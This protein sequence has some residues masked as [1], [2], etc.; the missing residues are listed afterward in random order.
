[1]GIKIE[2]SSYLGTAKTFLKIIGT[3][4]GRNMNCQDIS[5]SWRSFS[6]RRSYFHICHVGEAVFDKYPV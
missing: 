2:G 4:V 6:T 3:F 1:M 5:T